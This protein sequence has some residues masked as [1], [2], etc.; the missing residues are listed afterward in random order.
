MAF[1]QNADGAGGPSYSGRGDEA[2]S[3]DGGVEPRLD[4][5]QY[6]EDIVSMCRAHSVRDALLH[7]LGEWCEAG[8]PSRLYIYASE[9]LDP[10]GGWCWTPAL[11]TAES[12]V[13]AVDLD[14]FCRRF[15]L[16]RDTFFIFFVKSSARSYLYLEDDVSRRRDGSAGS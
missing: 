9:R 11:N 7:T 12:D 14:F 15:R 6:P 2:Q 5:G 10:E 4:I 1:G 8:V 13:A 16:T 3:S